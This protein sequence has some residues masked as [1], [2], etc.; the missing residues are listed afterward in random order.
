MNWA[1]KVISELVNYPWTFWIIWIFMDGWKT[2]NNIWAFSQSLNFWTNKNKKYFLS[3]RSDWELLN[4][5]YG[6]KNNIWA[7]E[8]WGR[9][10]TTENSKKS[11]LAISDISDKWKLENN[12]L[13]ELLYYLW[14]FRWIKNNKYFLSFRAA[15]ELKEDYQRVKTNSWAFAK[16]ISFQLNEKTK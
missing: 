14:V 13:T 10:H 12:S 1:S 15:W 7:F 5:Y 2:K 3:F 11:F 6:V 8:K 4:E 16:F 9:F